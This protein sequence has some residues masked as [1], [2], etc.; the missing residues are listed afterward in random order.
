[1]PEIRRGFWIPSAPLPSPPAGSSFAFPFRTRP[2]LPFEPDR[3]S[4]LNRVRNQR[5]RTRSTTTA[6]GS[7]RRDPHLA[8]RTFVRCRRRIGSFGGAWE[9]AGGAGRTVPWIQD[10]RTRLRG[11]GRRKG[12]EGSTWDGDGTWNERASELGRR[13]WIAQEGGTMVR[14]GMEEA[15]S[16][17]CVDERLCRDWNGKN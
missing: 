2:D 17:R 4:L 16:G 10:E 12:A 3:F 8:S 14:D 1:M 11:R 15:T 6:I 13:A 9:A 5:R 7:W